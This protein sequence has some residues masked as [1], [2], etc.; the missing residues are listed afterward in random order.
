LAETVVVR[1]ASAFT[2]DASIAV[3]SADAT[4]FRPP[5]RPAPCD[6]AAEVATDELERLIAEARIKRLIRPGE[7]ERALERAGRRKGTARLRALLKA[8][9]RPGVT[10][11]EA[12]RI[13]RRLLK[14]ADL[15][16]NQRVGG[17]L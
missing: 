12:E 8:E 11:S 5:R 4:A 9:G 17:G 14:R 1:A 16:P 13:L 10:R 15:P 6:L 3:I 2:V 7:L